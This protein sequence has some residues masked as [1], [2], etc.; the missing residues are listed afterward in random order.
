MLK[1]LLTKPFSQVLFC[2]LLRNCLPS[3]PHKMCF[4]S[5]L[6]MCPIFSLSLFSG[7]SCSNI[8]WKSLNNTYL[9]VIELLLF[10]TNC[11]RTVYTYIHKS[12]F[13]YLTKFK[14][15]VYSN[16]SQSMKPVLNSH[17]KLFVSSRGMQQLFLGCPSLAFLWKFWYSRKKNLFQFWNRLEQNLNLDLKGFKIGSH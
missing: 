7:R 15:S 14:H 10:M 16:L 13:K 3:Q 4:S 12:T 5:H 6:F 1:K 17:V 11:A 8:E 9:N 2:I